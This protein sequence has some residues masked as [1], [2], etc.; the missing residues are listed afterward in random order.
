M[1]SYKNYYGFQKEP[2]EQKIEIKDLYPIPGLDPLVQRFLYAVNL[3]T[4]AVVTG[5]VGAGKSTSIRYAA[6]K[7][8]PSAYKIIPIIANTGTILEFMR[9]ICLAI[10]IECNSHSITTLIKIVKNSFLEVASR[11]QKPVLIVDEPNLMRLDVFAQIHTMMQFEFDSKPIVT[12]ILCGQSNLI[13]KLMY[14][15]TRPL[16]S[17]IVAR[18]HLEGL[19]LKDMEGYLNHHLQIAGSN[20]QLFAQEAILAIMQGSGG[21]LRRANIIAR[22][23]LIAAAEEKCQ[24]V[25]AEHVRIAS[26]EI[27]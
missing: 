16:A 25:S 6:N 15:T 14:H 26:S 17:R 2:F 11:K 27:I 19:K 24:T 20:D 23:A 9:Q 22:G 21:L 18:S 3:S 4:A 7:L 5:D 10:D 13:D 1:K 12:L 8:H